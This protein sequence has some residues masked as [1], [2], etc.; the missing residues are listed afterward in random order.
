MN[1]KIIV[2]LLLIYFVFFALI[3]F[4]TFNHFDV[5]TKKCGERIFVIAYKCHSESAGDKAKEIIDNYFASVENCMSVDIF[6]D[7]NKIG[8][9]YKVHVVSIGAIT[10]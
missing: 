2:G 6:L 10:N 8:P 9:C 7:N 4:S 1:K 5:V 3:K